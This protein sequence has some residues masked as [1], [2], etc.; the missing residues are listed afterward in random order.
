M[1][2]FDEYLGEWNIFTESMYALSRKEFT[3]DQAFDQLKE[4]V[5]LTAER[6]GMVEGWARFECRGDMGEDNWS[7]WV[8][9]FEPV[10]RGLPVWIYKNY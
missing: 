7:G 6:S 1:S 9:Y 2:K 8:L 5:L 10:K 4:Q 3:E